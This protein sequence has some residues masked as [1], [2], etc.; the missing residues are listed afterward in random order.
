MRKS[1]IIIGIAILFA[2]CQA[3]TGPKIAV[4]SHMDT[5]QIPEQQ[6]LQAINATRS[7]HFKIDSVY[8]VKSS[9]FNVAKATNGDLSMIFT[10]E[11]NGVFV[12]YYY[13]PRKGPNETGQYQ[14]LRD[15]K[16]LLTVEA[17][18]SSGCTMLVYENGKKL[19]NKISLVKK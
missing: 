6:A 4:D 11:R 14:Q 1:F 10:L 16:Y 17:C 7:T 18:D 8:R 12:Q 19:L 5:L 13:N 3:T 9:N 15:G 2:A